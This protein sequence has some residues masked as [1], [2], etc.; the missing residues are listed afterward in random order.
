MSTSRTKIKRLSAAQRRIND[1]ALRLFATKGSV[2]VGISELA[3]AAGVARGTIY[4]N[5]ESPEHL[6]QQVAAQLAD[7]MDERV[8]ASYVGIDDPAERI[9]IGI[10]LYTQRAHEQPHWG[11]FLLNFAYTNESLRKIWRGPPMNDLMMGLKSGRFLFRQDQVL[12]CLGVIAGSTLSAIMGVTEG[13]RTWRDAGSDAAE[14]SLRALGVNPVEAK[15]IANRN[16]PTLVD[17]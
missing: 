14:L 13:L 17:V 1:A 3:D 15:D 11:R 10:R 6:F 12:G 8:A 7:E 4:N 16:L 9:S 5:L 2:D